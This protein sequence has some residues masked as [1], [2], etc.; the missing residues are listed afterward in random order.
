ML[1][2][3][4]IRENPDAV[5]ENIK[6]KFQ[7][8]KLPLVDE[9]LD[10]DSKRR[11]AIAE[12]DQLRSNRNTLSKQIGMLMGQAKKDP[13]KLA[14]AEAV[15]AQVKEQADRLAELEAQFQRL[16][17]K[18]ADDPIAYGDQF[19]EILDEQTALKELRAT[20]LAESKEHAEADRRIRDAAGMLENAVPHIAEWDETAIRQLVAQ[21]KVLSKNE[22]SVTLKSGI[23]IRQ[24]ISN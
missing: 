2:I 14:E 9:V 8:A 19:K 13:A 23:E 5:R 1:D 16:L 4:F 21:V 20:I 18:A 10:L 11:A 7:D 15:K 22:I 12:A 6:K 24:S 17:E 3:K